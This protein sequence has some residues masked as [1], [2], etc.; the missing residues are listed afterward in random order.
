MSAVESPKSNPRRRSRISVV[1]QHQERSSDVTRK[2]SSIS[3]AVTEQIRKKS[4]VFKEWI[5]S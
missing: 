5:N 2:V 3:I 4:T 1:S